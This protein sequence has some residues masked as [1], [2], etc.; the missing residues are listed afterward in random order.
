MLDETQLGTWLTGTSSSA[1]YASSALLASG[2]WGGMLRCAR[3]LLITS[4]CE[5]IEKDSGRH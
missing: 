5:G 2:W 4:S 3:L 1:R